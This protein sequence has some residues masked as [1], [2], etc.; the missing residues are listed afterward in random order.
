MFARSALFFLAL[1]TFSSA[2]YVPR[3][4]DVNA[5]DARDN[6]SP[7]IQRE[8]YSFVN[9]RDLD[10]LEIRD[11]VDAFLE[12]RSHQTKRHPSPGPPSTSSSGLKGNAS[13]G[14][15][16]K[17]GSGNKG[18]DKGGNKGGN[19]GGNSGGNKGGNSGGNKGGNSGGNSGGNKGG[20]GKRDLL[21]VEVREVP[22][23]TG[24]GPAQPTPANNSGV[25]KVKISKKVLTKLHSLVKT[26]VAR[27]EASGKSDSIPTFKAQ[28]KSL[29]A[30][31]ENGSKP[32]KGFLHSAETI[33]KSF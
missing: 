19:S 4:P 33:A 7:L 20:K 32:V 27:L 6:S 14:S 11:L 17:G 5:L 9:S 1:A 3:S 26:T 8:P 2:L 30:Q 31:V 21:E 10:E 25:P 18:G 12:A 28:I 15:G 16:D 29:K 22:S 13:G 23:T 24:T